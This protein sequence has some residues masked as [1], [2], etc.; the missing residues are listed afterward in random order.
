MI[1]Y[2]RLSI[3]QMFF[4]KITFR[5]TDYNLFWKELFRGQHLQGIWNEVT[6]PANWFTKNYFLRSSALF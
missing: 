6:T 5:Q 4:T 1:L 2:Y 3:Q